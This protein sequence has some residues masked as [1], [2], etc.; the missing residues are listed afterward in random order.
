MSH[1]EMGSELFYLMPS[2]LS[3]RYRTTT[4]NPSGVEQ[5]LLQYMR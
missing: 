3:V 5:G 2:R 1:G 4:F